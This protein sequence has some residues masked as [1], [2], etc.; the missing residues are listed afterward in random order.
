MFL[1]GSPKLPITEPTT[2]KDLSQKPEK[3]IVN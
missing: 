1:R 2:L 3:L